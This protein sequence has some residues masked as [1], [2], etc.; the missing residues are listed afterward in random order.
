M[1]QKEEEAVLWI[2]SVLINTE[3]SAS[4]R[5]LDTSM[6]WQSKTCEG[7]VPWFCKE[8]KIFFYEM[9]EQRE[10][11][12]HQETVEVEDLE[13]NSFKTISTVRPGIKSSRLWGLWPHVSWPVW[14]SWLGIFQCTKRLLVLF[15]VRAHAQRC[16][17]DP[18]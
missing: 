18:Q 1:N 10:I 13:I 2:S 8:E 3:G 12:W 17:L 16:G 5:C 15:T 7:W 6:V 4:W 14:F 11:T 9:G